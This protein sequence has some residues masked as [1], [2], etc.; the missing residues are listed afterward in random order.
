MPFCEYASVFA[1]FAA[2]VGLRPSPGILFGG[3]RRFPTLATLPDPSCW[4]LLGL[5]NGWNLGSLGMF[6]GGSSKLGRLEAAG[7]R[8]VKLG[9]PPT[10][11]PACIEG[12]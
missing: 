8:A 5:L 1:K 10:F 11:G 6:G 2:L 9:G 12:G 7:F 3:V 4:P